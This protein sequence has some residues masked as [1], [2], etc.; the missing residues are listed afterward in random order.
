MIKLNM[1]V[2][3]DFTGILYFYL[4]ISVNVPSSLAIIVIIV[5]LFL[6]NAFGIN[7]INAIVCSDKNDSKSGFPQN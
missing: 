3:D 6:F 5:F 4:Q 2:D 7:S 1:Y